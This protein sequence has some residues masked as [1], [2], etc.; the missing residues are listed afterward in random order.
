MTAPVFVLLAAVA[1]ASGFAG[2][3][4]EV[5]WTRMLAAAVGTEM[6]ATLGVVTG[7]FAGLASGALAL[8]RAI[9]RAADPRRAFAALELKIALWALASVFLLP[10]V[11]P[12]LATLV[13]PAPPPPLLWLAGFGMPALALLPATAAMGGTL[14]ALER[15]VAPLSRD[16]RVVA[17]IYGAN[18]AG[19]AAGCLAGVFLLLPQL[20]VSRTLGAL[21]AVNASAAAA[22]LLLPRPTT[23]APPPRRPL[24]GGIRLL[25]IL[26][27]TGLLG[28]ALETLVI[29]LAAQVLQNTIFSFA[30]LLAAYLIGTAIGG[31]LWQRARQKPGAPALGALLAAASLTTT[32]TAALALWLGPL[33]LAAQLGSVGAEFLLAGAL[34]LLPTIAMGAL[35]GA[36]AQTWRDG[37]GSLGI[38]VAANAAGAAVAPP[39][40]AL[41]LIPLTGAA[42]GLLVVAVGFLLLAPLLSGAVPPRRWWIGAVPLAAAAAVLLLRPDHV[43]VRVPAGGELLASQEGPT[44]T[45]SVVADAD[46]TR[47]LEINGHFRM[48][49]TSS[50][51]SDWR[52]AQIP[53]LLHPAPHRALFLGVGTGATLAGAG[54]WPGLRATGVELVPE[55]VELLPWFAAPGAPALPPIVTADARRFVR[56]E[57]DRYDVI[58]A[59][60]FHPALDG[61]GALYTAEHFAAVRERLA[62]G[63]V[64]CQWLP[65]YQLDQPS[66]GAIIRSFQAVFPGATAWLAHYSLQTPMLALIGAPDGLQTD[67]AQLARR[68]TAAALRPALQPTGLLQPLDLLGLFVGG[69]AALEAIAGP[70]PRN[71]DDRPVVA[72]DAERNVRALS[73]PPTAGLLAV[74]GRAATTP[75]AEPG[76]EASPEMAA[77]R[78]ARD[79]FIAAGAAIEPGLDPRALMNAA[80]PGLLDA[81]RLSPEF[82]PAYDPLVAMAAALLGPASDADDRAAAIRILQA[83]QAA[84][85]GRPEAPHLLARLRGP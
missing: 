18:T 27:G 13:G 29:R 74:L 64:F 43:L 34:F 57:R 61:S 70:G 4:Y 26:A 40:T 3:A 39:L 56:A 35:F 78:R 47:F 21:A 41:A 63:G 55:A 60:L 11:G 31:L 84:A 14:I 79:R 53:L 23:A 73:A 58:V 6:M 1:A 45:A 36:V 59:D 25:L 54:V 7:F 44:A 83:A 28:I 42:S 71:T 69:P 51:R 24:G 67:P 9:D 20:G 16:G 38:A 30:V 65:L 15:M 49:G 5:V 50:R 37:G 2:L 10:A 76:I 77:Y 17:G 85:P 12:W 75:V 66:L 68:M 8:R 19:A 80:I 72:L 52:Q 62:P 33:A 46:G 22:A 81:L 48:G 32:A 82:G